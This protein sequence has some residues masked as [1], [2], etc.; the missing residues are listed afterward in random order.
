ALKP[1]DLAYQVVKYRQRNGWSHTDLLRLAHPAPT[2]ETHGAIYQWITRRDESAWATADEQPTDNAL[3]FVWAFE[4]VQK[5]DHVKQ[6]I[7]L[8]EDFDLPREALPTEWLKDAQ[9]WEALLEKMPLTAMIRNL[10]VMAQVGLLKPFSQAESTIVKRLRDANLLKKARI[11]PI[12][13]LSALRVYGQGKGVRGSGEW[14]PTQKTID[15]LDEA[16]YLAFGAVEPSNKRVMLAL[17][18]SGSMGASWVAGVP[19]LTPRDA[20]AAL[21]LVTART[22]PNY[23]ITAFSTQMIPLNISAKMRLNDAIATVSGLPFAGTDCALPMLYAL[24]NKLKVDQFVVLTDSETWHGG[25]HPVQALQQYRRETGIQARLVVVGMVA[26]KFT[27]ADPND[28]GMLDVVGMD[29]ATPQLIS[30]FAKG[31]I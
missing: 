10:G 21:A 19:G 24:E 12:A 1:R 5:V 27:I 4:R 20:T 17:D 13:V 18:V 7:K 3:A 26:N 9:V 30:D 2:D 23:M 8:I 22:E 14:T 11:H 29:T 16:F 28:R 31:V 15:A 25:I 6:V